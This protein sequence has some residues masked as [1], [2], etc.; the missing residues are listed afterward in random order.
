[1]NELLSIW[2]LY[3]SVSVVFWRRR[4]RAWRIGSIYNFQCASIRQASDRR[5][6]SNLSFDIVY[7]CLFEQKNE[8]KKVNIECSFVL[9]I[10]LNRIKKKRSCTSTVD[11]PQPQTTYCNF[12]LRVQFTFENGFLRSLWWF[13]IRFFSKN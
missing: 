8:K 2:M 5:M 12:Q 6:K 4:R 7:V 11:G 1:M 13:L 10:W 3:A 9:S